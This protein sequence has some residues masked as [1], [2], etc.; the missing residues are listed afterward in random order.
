MV[1]LRLK[2]GNR[3]DSEAARTLVVRAVQFVEWQ[4]DQYQNAISRCTRGEERESK[5]D[6]NEEEAFAKIREEEG[7]NKLGRILLS[8]ITLH[9]LL[10]HT[11]HS[12]AFLVKI[13]SSQTLP[14]SS[15]SHE[16]PLFRFLS[17]IMVHT[18]FPSHSY[19]HPLLLRF[20]LS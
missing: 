17:P 7:R 9:T 5:E 1:H 16:K 2:T 13:L 14:F 11:P 12:C 18:V 15:P 3:E 10:G 19:R 8:V 20:S 4:A 6:E